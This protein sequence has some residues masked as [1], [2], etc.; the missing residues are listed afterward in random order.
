MIPGAIYT[1]LEKIKQFSGVPADRETVTYCACPN[2][3]S[4]ARAALLLRKQGF[5]H[6]RP[7]SGGFRG[8]RELN[9]PVEDLTGRRNL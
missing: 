4:V 9:C 5:A 1:P 6:V 8:W 3:V 2:D 7:L